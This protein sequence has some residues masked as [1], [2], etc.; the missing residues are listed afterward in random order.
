[1]ILNS[2]S[3]AKDLGISSFFCS[4]LALGLSVCYAFIYM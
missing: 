1:M 3:K 4:I 2:P